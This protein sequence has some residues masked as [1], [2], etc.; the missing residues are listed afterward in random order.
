MSKGKVTAFLYSATIGYA[1]SI[2][3][4]LVIDSAA[5]ANEAGTFAAGL[6]AV[7]LNEAFSSESQGA[8]GC[9]TLL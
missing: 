4:D 6:A 8:A 3:T 1:A 7:L 5:L 2:P 9:L